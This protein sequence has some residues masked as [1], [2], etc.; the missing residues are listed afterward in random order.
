M[1]N[2]TR[3]ITNEK[4]K[5]LLDRFV[6]LIKDTRYFDCLVGYFYTSGF[7]SLYKSLER[8]EKIRVLIGISTNKQTFNLIQ[9]S[10][11]EI[12]TKLEFSHKQ[13]K[14]QF[15]NMVINELENSQDS[16][17]VEEGIK[18]FVERLQSGKLEVRVYPTERIHAKMYVMTF[19]E[20]DREIGRVITG[21]S[22]FTE[23]GLKDNIELNVAKDFAQAH[24]FRIGKKINFYFG[25]E[26]Q[27]KSQNPYMLP[28]RPDLQST[29]AGSG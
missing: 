24:I 8:T 18:K 2:D 27:K 16:A 3:F 11:K 20:G 7:Y 23:A 4:D 12:Q 25:R 10:K 15:S 13:T 6:T 1:S 29:G 22:N 19:K 21:S 26:N 9:E 14:E 5:K 28:L 17:S